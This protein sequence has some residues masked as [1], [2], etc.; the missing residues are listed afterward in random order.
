MAITFHCQHC[1]KKIEAPE[2]AGGKYGKCPSCHNK[3]YVPNPIPDDEEDFKLAPIDQTEEE[4]K[5]QLM[6]ETY[7][8][9]QDILGE[10]ETP[11][12]AAPAPS[13]L[14]DH[15]LT[16]NVV[17]Y[18]R[19]MADGELEEAQAVARSLKPFAR[20]AIKILDEIAVAD[21]PEPELSDIPQQVL[22]KMIK[23]LR[24]NLT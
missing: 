20:D 8:L 23:S 19:Y 22:S 1:G 6:A 13:Q 18:L 2:S 4:K 3:V 24:A 15:E 12:G 21:I 7:R 11:E 16:E 10:K 5:K 17:L 9:T 14:S